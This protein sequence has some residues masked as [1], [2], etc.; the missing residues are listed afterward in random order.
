MHNFSSDYFISKR[1]EMVDRYIRL[2]YLHS[3]S[4]IEAMRKVP[5]EIFM[6]ENLL[7][8]AYVDEPFPIPGNGQQTI[9]APYTYPLFYEPLKL[10]EGDR[11]LEVGMGSGY[12]AALARELVG[13]QGLVVTVEINK[14]T[15]E[16]GLGNLKKA[17]YDDIRTIYSDGS[18]GFIELAPYNKICVTAACPKI[19]KPLINQLATPGM[20]IAP[21][22]PLSHF[23]GQDLQLLIKDK[24]G[25]E[26]IRNLSKVVYV[27]LQG[28][29]GWNKEND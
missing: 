11:V 3:Q 10:T 4:M 9:S 29:F 20:L 16:F 12:G 17:G 23:Y 24:L 27:P 19:P 5:R 18:I 2:G 8:H 15:Y 7:Q 21:V 25:N 26:K 14:E 13:D 28:K 22:G 1:K 6:S